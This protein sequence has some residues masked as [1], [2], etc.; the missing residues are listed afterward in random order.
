MT[1][2]Q[3]FRNYL[4][5]HIKASKSYMQSRMRTRVSMLLE[6]KFCGGGMW[7]SCVLCCENRVRLN[8]I[9]CG[10]CSLPCSLR[11]LSRIVLPYILFLGSPYISSHAIPLEPFPPLSSGTLSATGTPSYPIVPLRTVLKDAK[12]QVERTKKK[13]V[14]AG[15]RPFN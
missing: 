4:H 14:T 5:Y 12:P 11:T 10:L 8:L 6:S 2:L 7:L 13:K 1:L 15:G 3:G 9:E